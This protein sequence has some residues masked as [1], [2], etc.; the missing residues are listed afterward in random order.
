M[1]PGPIVHCRSSCSYC[2]HVDWYN[3]ICGIS[4][5]GKKSYVNPAVKS[6]IDILSL[7]GIVAKPQSLASQ[8][9]VNKK[10]T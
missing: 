10:Q 3:D 4:R 1:H 6:L 5:K 8:L 7:L 9:L 2:K